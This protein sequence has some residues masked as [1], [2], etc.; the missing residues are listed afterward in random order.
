[1]LRRLIRQKLYLNA[2]NLY[3]MQPTPC[4]NT[5]LI[6]FAK[7]RIKADIDLHLPSLDNNTLKN[8][9]L[10]AIS[11]KN[12]K[13]L[14]QAADLRPSSIFL[15]CLM[16][17]SQLVLG[18]VDWN[19]Y[20]SLY[21]SLQSSRFDVT[22]FYY[23]MLNHYARTLDLPKLLVLRRHVNAQNLKVDTLNPILYCIGR[24]GLFRVIA[25]WQKL[26]ETTVLKIAT[27]EAMLDCLYKGEMYDKMQLLYHRSS[28]KTPYMHLAMLKLYLA[29]RDMESF[30]FTLCELYNEPHLF[31]SI[32]MV[33]WKKNRET[34]RET[35][36]I[37]ET[38]MQARGFAISELLSKLYHHEK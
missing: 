2:L 14:K 30:R 15:R 37:Y 19:N 1:M 38:E 13:L 4:L 3:R 32:L 8:A 9:L 36:P 28:I 27:K 34:F 16:I 26:A 6:L 18:N 31:K 24:R 33:L 5:R 12:Y 35:Y 23:L 20:L 29:T 21:P 17:R 22:H 11:T 25:H 7:A 10:F